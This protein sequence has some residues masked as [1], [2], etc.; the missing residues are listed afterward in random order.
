LLYPFS[1]VALLFVIGEFFQKIAWKC[2]AASAVLQFPA[3]AACLDRAFLAPEGFSDID[4]AA[5]L[6]RLFIFALAA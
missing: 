5:A 4:A 3:F 6:H 1:V 2:V